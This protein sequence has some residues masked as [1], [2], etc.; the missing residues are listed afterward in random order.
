MVKFA[1]SIATEPIMESNKIY[2]LV[3]LVFCSCMSGNDTKNG[4]SND[5]DSALSNSVRESER[6]DWVIEGDSITMKARE[7]LAQLSYRFNYD[8]STMI[9]K[10]IFVYSDLVKIQEIKVNKM[11]FTKEFQLVDW[12]F[13]GYKDISVLFNCGSG[14]C[15]YYIWNYSPETGKYHYND[16]LSEVFGLEIDTVL[17]AIVIHYR[18]GYAVEYW[19]TYQYIDDTLAF[20][21]G[22]Y[23]ERGSDSLGN[24][25]T[26]R[27]YKKIV[28]GQLVISVDSVENTE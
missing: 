15:E 8:S 25:W 11:I 28:D 12:N 4:R 19:N 18:A 17:K 9:L 7:G 24:S 27:T 13:D 2:T 26:K 21:H 14:G 5:Q 23:Q 22:V 10:S 20:F 3:F 1:C 16:V 6:L